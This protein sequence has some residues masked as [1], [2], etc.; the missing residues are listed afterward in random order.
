MLTATTAPAA[1][2]HMNFLQAIVLGLIQGVYELFPLSS[3]GHTV[4]IPSWIGGNWAL[5]VKQESLS[6][7]PYLAFVVALHLANAIA[8]VLFY[9]REW[10]RLIAG[11]FRSLARRR[12]ETDTE[13][14]AWLI[15][16]ATIPVGILGLLLEHPFRTL[17]AKPLAAA[18]FLTVNGVILGAGEW[19]RRRPRPT[20]E[21]AATP[22]AAAPVAALQGRAA[23]MGRLRDE[24]IVTIDANAERELNAQISWWSTLWIGAA[25]S[26][27]LLAGISREGVAMVGGLYRGLSNENA[28]RFAFLLS[29]PVIFAAGAL[30]VPD[31]LGPL[32][33]GIRGQAI[34]GAGAAVI[35]SFAAIFFLAR[36]FKTRTLRPFAIYSILFGVASVVRFGIF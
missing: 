27:A 32:G 5:L 1:I 36:Y 17:F 7:S 23:T 34:A 22:D 4:L 9:I 8:L 19:Y 35:A 24:N 13:R 18:A 3:L 21:N 16:I 6:E 15:V 2:Y 10:V 12:I 20:P 31:L 25:Q 14:L 26:L 29:A 28:L 11:F 33:N 30:K